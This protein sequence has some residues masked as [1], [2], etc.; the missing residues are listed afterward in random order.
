MNEY[1]FNIK[2]RLNILFKLKVMPLKERIQIVSKYH[3]NNKASEIIKDRYLVRNKNEKGYFL[4][5]RNRFYFDVDY[6]VNNYEILKVG[7]SQTIVEAFV[8]PLLFSKKVKINPGDVCFDLGANI[9]TT[10]VIFSQLS[11]NNG[12]VYAFEPVI[13]H[14][15]KKNM[16]I[17]NAKNVTVFDY[18][19]SDKD[20]SVE[21]EISDFCSDSSIA[22][23]KFSDGF[24]SCKKT[25]STITLDTFIQKYNLDR[26]DFI[27]I[28][29]EGAEELA[30]RG[31]DVLIKRFKPKFSI[32]SY[33]I[34][35]QNQPQHSKLVQI[36]KRDYGYKIETLGR[37][38]IFAWK[39]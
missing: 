2:S 5:G 13:P 35:F 19:I 12:R 6:H 33:H 38:H 10:S 39:D 21:I 23:R 1:L 36:L 16:T 26:V 22:K 3:I 37:K 9:G 20:G 18:G 27:K 31:A 25:I 11:G 24:Y 15:L 8:N 4:F 34:D 7:V 14:L 17:N 29:I 28:D 30:I 32:S